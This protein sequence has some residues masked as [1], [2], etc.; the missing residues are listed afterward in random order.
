MSRVNLLLVTTAW[1]GPLR[2]LRVFVGGS[3]DGG[4]K[5]EDGAVGVFPS[6]ILNLLSSPRAPA[7][8][9]LTTASVGRVLGPGTADTA[10][11]EIGRPTVGETRRGEISLSP[12][13][14]VSL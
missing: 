13:L 2:N 12:C 5:M 6:S 14:L 7:T 9:E 3:E 10:A 4:W 11:A 8:S 1:N